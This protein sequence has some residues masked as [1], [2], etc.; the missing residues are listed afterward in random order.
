MAKKNSLMIAMMMVAGLGLGAC[1]KDA[2]KYTLDQKVD[3][4]VKQIAAETPDQPVTDEMKKRIR[5]Q[6]AQQEAIANAA[7]Q[8][9]LDKNEDVKVLSAIGAEQA[10]ASKFLEAKMASFKPSDEE[11]KKI[12][13]EQV[14]KGKEYHLRHILVETEDQAKDIIAKLK[15]GEKFEVLAKQS[16]DPGSAVKGGDLGWMPLDA[17]VPEFKEAA[18]KLQPHQI[19]ET[20]VKSQFGYH[21]IQLV[22]EPRTPQN[23]PAFEAVK[24]QVI[25][26]A[27]R[28]HLKQLQ[29]SFTQK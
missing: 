1:A 18:S 15:A 6:L 13:D 7:R 19:T 10:L 27:K 14:S 3:A 5:E 23:V 28:D 20:P 16:K 29:D 8:D 25:E 2:T 4:I 22:E 26:M 11:L 17:W 24:P 9:G 12:Y 21:V